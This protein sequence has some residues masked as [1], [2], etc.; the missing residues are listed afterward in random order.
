MVAPTTN[1]IKQGGVLY[2]AKEVWDLTLECYFHC[3]EQLD[4]EKQKVFLIF[5]NSRTSSMVSLSRAPFLLA[6]ASLF[7]QIRS[8]CG[9]IQLQADT[10]IDKK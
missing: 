1:N 2:S 8:K 7:F 10:D 3:Y 5:Y 6:A 4:F 9:A